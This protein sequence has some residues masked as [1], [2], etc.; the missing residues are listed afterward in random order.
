MDTVVRARWIALAGVA[1]ALTSAV[2]R[3]L[4]VVVIGGVAAVVVAVVAWRRPDRASLAFALSVVL[5]ALAWVPFPTAL[6]PV[7]TI[8]WT[9]AQALLVTFGVL[10]VRRSSGLVRIAGWVVSVGAAAWLLG[11][12]AL[13]SS[14]VLDASQETL[15][16]L[17]AVPAAGQFIAFVAAALLFAGPLLRPVGD[18]ARYLWS[19]ADVR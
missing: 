5:Q 4:P 7:S 1:A 19:T 2:D 8:L 12:L 15:S 3:T 14:V 17:F 10:V 13:S 11:T 18:G 6:W 16:A 9:A